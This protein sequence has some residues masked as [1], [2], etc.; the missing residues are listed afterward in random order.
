[1]KMKIQLIDDWKWVVTKAWSSR[2]M[3]VAMI[4]TG[5]EAIIPIFSDDLTEL[6]PRKYV[7]LGIFL[8]I[9]TAWIARLLVQRQESNHD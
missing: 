6:Y 5:C 1:M 4:L 7:A 8:I 3:L 2:L 9:G